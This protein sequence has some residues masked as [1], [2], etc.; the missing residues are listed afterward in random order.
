VLFC[1]IQVAN[2][3][4]WIELAGAKRAGNPCQQIRPI[5]LK[6]PPPG[7]TDRQQKESL[8][9]MNSI[10]YIEDQAILDDEQLSTRLG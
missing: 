3:P 2:K 8:D 10:F 4:W 5:S 9:S 1:N 7:A 6:H